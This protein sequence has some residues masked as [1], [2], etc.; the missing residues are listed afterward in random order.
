MAMENF[1]TEIISHNKK[2]YE[3][4]RNRKMWST[5]DKLRI[6]I[7]VVITDFGDGQNSSWQK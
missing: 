4:W 5:V 7:K 3:L 2:T 6:L 1:R